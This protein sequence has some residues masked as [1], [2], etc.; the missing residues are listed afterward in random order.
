LP[1]NVESQDNGPDRRYGTR[2]FLPVHFRLAHFASPI[3]TS[4]ISP[5]DFALPISPRPFRPARS[6]P[7]ATVI[8]PAENAEDHGLTGTPDLFSIG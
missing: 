6:S 1:T 2:P 5:A 7:A 8:E 4:P 3:S